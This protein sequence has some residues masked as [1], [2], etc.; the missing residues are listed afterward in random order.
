MLGH[1]WLVVLL[2]LVIVLILVG[3][4]KLSQLGEAMGRS[5]RD[6]R[7]TS[8][9]EVESEDKSAPSTDKPSDGG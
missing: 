4:G 3:P 2:I 5:V 8:K 7:K 1:S 6:F 9:G